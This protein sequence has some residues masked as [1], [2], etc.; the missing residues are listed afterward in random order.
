MILNKRVGVL[1]N[2]V[3]NDFKKYLTS[4]F[5]SG[6]YNLTPE[7]FLLMDALWDDGI[8][9]QQTLADTMFKDKNSIVK[10]IDGLEKRGYVKRITDKNDRR[11][12]L[13]KL[14]NH[15]IVLKDDVTRLAMDAVNTIIKDI[16]K[17]KLDIFIQV[18]EAMTFNVRGN[19][20]T[21]LDIKN[22]KDI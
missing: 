3:H 14:T 10:L 19:K 11:Q 8:Q 2:L 15:G 16:E 6:G 17:E 4:V 13:I 21:Y 22:N 18:L 12:N 9:S 5:K 7:Q 1:L 20:N